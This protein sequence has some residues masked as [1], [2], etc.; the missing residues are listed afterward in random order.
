MGKEKADKER[1]P[2]SAFSCA[3]IAPALNGRGKF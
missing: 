3:M 1:S 2:T